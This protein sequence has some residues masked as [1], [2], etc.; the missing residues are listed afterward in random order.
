VFENQVTVFCRGAGGFGGKKTGNGDFILQI[1][2]SFAW[3]ALLTAR[4]DRGAATALNK[5]PKREPD[6]IVETK[7]DSKQ[8]AIYR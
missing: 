2:C 4:T 3:S 8:A 7:T 1:T 5:P 6:A